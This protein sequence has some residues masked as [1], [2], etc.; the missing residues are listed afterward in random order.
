M[1]RFRKFQEDPRIECHSIPVV[2][3]EE[4]DTSHR[5]AQVKEQL[6]A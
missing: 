4:K 6:I 5:K 3:E 2:P 1:T